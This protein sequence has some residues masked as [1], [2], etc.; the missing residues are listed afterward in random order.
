MTITCSGGSANNYDFDTSTNTAE[1][2]IDPATSN[3]T[4]T[5]T[6]PTNAVYGGTYDVTT[7]PGLSTGSVVLRIAED[8]A[9]VRKVVA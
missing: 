1:L 4:F 7:S 9:P 3:P 2:T 5:S 6:A 8:S